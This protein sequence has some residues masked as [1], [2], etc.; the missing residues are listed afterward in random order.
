[1]I[2]EIWDLISEQERLSNKNNID[3]I[4]KI[5]DKNDINISRHSLK[6]WPLGGNTVEPEKESIQ[7]S[8]GQRKMIKWWINERTHSD[9]LGVMLFKDSSWFSEPQQQLMSNAALEGY[10]HIFIL[11]YHLQHCYDFWMMLSHSCIWM[12]VG[13]MHPP[14]LTVVPFVLKPKGALHRMNM[15][16]EHHW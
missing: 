14:R 15:G 1:M 8:W 5:L 2:F 12:N 10:F 13:R 11:V 4:C 16:D 7:I 9:H 6:S 3:Q